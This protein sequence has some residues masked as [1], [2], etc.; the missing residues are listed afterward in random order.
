ML[1][2]RYLLL[3][4]VGSVVMRG[5][6]CVVNDMWDSKLDRLEFWCF[7]TPRMV[8]RTKNRPLASGVLNHKQALDLL[9][10]QLLLGLGVLLQ[11]NWFAIGLGKNC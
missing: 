4:G 10:S 7:L 11:F 8:E 1:D 6:G 5:A 3:F 9:A 2:F